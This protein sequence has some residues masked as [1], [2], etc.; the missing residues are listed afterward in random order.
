VEVIQFEVV[1]RL[2]LGYGLS[3]DDID[4]VNV[5]PELRPTNRDGLIYKMT[6]RCVH[7]VNVIA[8]PLIKHVCAQ[9]LAVLVG[10]NG[11]TSRQH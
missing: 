7:Q 1:R 6:Q 5:L 3:L 10:N 8:L 4:E 9:R 11:R 2:H